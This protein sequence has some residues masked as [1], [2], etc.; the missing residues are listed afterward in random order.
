MYLGKHALLAAAV[1]GAS[2]VSAQTTRT[3]RPVGGF[4]PGSY[5]N[6]C[7][8]CG[9][10][11]LGS[12]HSLRCEVCG[13]CRE[14]EYLFASSTREIGLNE[15]GEPIFSRHL[16]AVSTKW[17]EDYYQQHSIA[18]R[19]AQHGIPLL[20]Q[21]PIAEAP[22]LG[23]GQILNHHYPSPLTIAEEIRGISD[24]LRDQIKWDSVSFCI[25]WGGEKKERT[26]WQARVG[27]YEKALTKRR[28]ASKAARKARKKSRN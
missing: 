7:P 16:P 1:I 8:E 17:L 11:Y 24:K 26:R 2:T 27:M 14:D 6:N 20:F 13:K 9:A 4:I 10:Q 3:Q 18:E 28:K 22:S 5:F 15:A 25:H 23:I 21:N 19:F 12:Q